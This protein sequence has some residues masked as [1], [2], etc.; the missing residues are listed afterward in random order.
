MTFAEYVSFGI[1]AIGISIIVIG[2]LLATW[3]YLNHHFLRDGKNKIFSTLSCHLILGLD[4]LVGKDVIDTL[5][6]DPDDDF[7]QSLARL[8]AIVFIRIILSFF[9]TKELQQFKD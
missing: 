6:L 4:F 7:W 5:L 1:G 9:L 2:A 8:G 3:E